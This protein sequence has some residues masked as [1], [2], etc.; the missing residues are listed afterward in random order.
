MH[1]VTAV[2]LSHLRDHLV[3]DGGYLFSNGK[4]LICVEG[5]CQHFELLTWKN[6][7]SKEIATSIGKIVNIEYISPPLSFSK[8]KNK[9]EQS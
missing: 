4:P 7:V 5:D 1:W 9:N 3:H 6:R 8:K 2:E